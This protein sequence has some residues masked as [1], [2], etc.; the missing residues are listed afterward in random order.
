[1]ANSLLVSLALLLLPSLAFAACNPPGSPVGSI[2]CRQSIA[3]PQASDLLLIWRPSAFPNSLGQYSLFDLLGAAGAAGAVSAKPAL[4]SCG[5]S[6]TIDAYA[7]NQSGTIVV[8]S[9]GPASCAITFGAPVYTTYNHCAVE[10]HTTL[11]SWGY[12]YTLTTLTVTG[13]SLSGSFDYVC[14]GK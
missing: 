2:G 3:P 11:A 8:G 6:P 1:M 9:G 4:G 12:S 5:V 13:T 7:T 10:P 14:D